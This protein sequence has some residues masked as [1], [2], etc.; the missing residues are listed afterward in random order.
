M[1]LPQIKLPYLPNDVVTKGQGQQHQI[2]E[3]LASLQHSLLKAKVLNKGRKEKSNN[4][5]TILFAL[6]ITSTA[7][8][9]DV[10]SSKLRVNNLMFHFMY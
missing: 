9:Y 3:L 4:D 8:S 10:P 1:H 5:A 6:L 7:L 2:K